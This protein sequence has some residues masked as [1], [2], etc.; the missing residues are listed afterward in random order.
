M[1][2][3]TMLGVASCS[4][5]VLALVG[6]PAAQAGPNNDDLT[7]LS[8]EAC[9][10]PGR[11]TFKFSLWYNSGQGGAFRNVHYA[12]YNFDALR[13]GDGHDHP[14]KF[15]QGGASSPWPG[16]LQRVKNNAAS[17]ENFHYKYK[18]RVYFKSGYKGAQDW[19]APYQHIDQ[20]LNVY[21]E[22]ASFQFTA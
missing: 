5:V 15:C 21:N 19:M 12:V 3:T 18:A 11:A 22:N 6:A 4:A 10:L 1:R 9:E 8:M 13:P 16:S 14:L 20:F 17:G 7:L 2:K